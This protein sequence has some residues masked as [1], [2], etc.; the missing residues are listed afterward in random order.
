[1]TKIHIEITNMDFC[2]A[3]HQGEN[4]LPCI[5]GID[6]HQIPMSLS[7]L[8]SCHLIRTFRDLQTEC[9]YT[10]FPYQKKER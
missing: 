1:M 10:E 8:A 7:L 5:S 6:E 2:S 9:V 4:L 3:C